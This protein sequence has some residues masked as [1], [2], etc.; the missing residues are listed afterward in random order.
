MCVWG[1]VYLE[2]EVSFKRKIHT[3][4]AKNIIK[5]K[6]LICLLAAAVILTL[7]FTKT[8]YFGHIMITK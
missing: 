7:I 3:F 8:I 6:L 5:Q 2:L 1:N 4:Y